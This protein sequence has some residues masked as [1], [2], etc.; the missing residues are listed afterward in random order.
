MPENEN[1]ITQYNNSYQLVVNYLLVFYKEIF[2]I[3]LYTI[4]LNE[5]HIFPSE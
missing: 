4:Y 1:E 5:R 3:P 2:R